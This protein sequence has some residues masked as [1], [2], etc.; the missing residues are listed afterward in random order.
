LIRVIS[1]LH[2][3]DRSCRLRSLAE[4]D[5]LFDGVDEVIVNGDALDTRAGPYPERT[6]QLGAEVTSYFAGKPA[7]LMTGNHDPDISELHWLPLAA[8][9]VLLIHG[10]M[11]FD[12]IVPWG[13]D[14]RAIQRLVAAGRAKLPPEVRGTLDAEARL[15]RAIAAGCKQRHQVETNPWRYLASFATDTFWP[16][17]RVQTI[18]KSWSEAPELAAGYARQYYPSARCLI[19]GHLHRPGYWETADGRHVVNTGCFC[20]PF[21]AWCADIDGDRVTARKLE[22]SPAGYR[23]GQIVSAIA[24]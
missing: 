24:M 7:R 21:Q 2:Y 12:T 20:R 10:D 19:L 22:R 11:L 1:D 14:A 16:P 3:G 23:P 5:P 15:F 9:K 13:K 8:G 17:T 4:L 18:L 6:R